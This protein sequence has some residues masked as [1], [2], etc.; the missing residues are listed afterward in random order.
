M[1]HFQ[2]GQAACD[3]SSVAVLVFLSHF[4]L[5]GL[6]GQLLSVAEGAELVADRLEN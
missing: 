1:L 3:F 5:G 6:L 2:V 4:E